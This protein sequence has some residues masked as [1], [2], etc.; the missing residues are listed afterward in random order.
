MCL[1]VCVRFLDKV[2]KTNDTDIARKDMDNFMTSVKKIINSK[3]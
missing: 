2:I 1:G 3:E